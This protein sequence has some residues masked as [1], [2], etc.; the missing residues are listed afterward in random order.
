MNSAHH[1][2]LIP[3][4]R[5]T[6][7]PG[8]LKL[9]A[10]CTLASPSAA[11]GLPLGQLAGDLSRLGARTAIRRNAAGPAAVRI[12][13][14]PRLAICGSDAV[15]AAV[16]GD[17][18]RLEITPDGATVTA[19]T[20]RGAYYG[21]QTLRELLAVH[22]KNLPCQ[23]IEDWPDFA[24]RGVYHDCSR[25]KVPTVATLKA[26]VERLARWKIN[27]LQL[28]IENTFT[29]HRHPAIG[30]GFSP[31]TPEELLDVQDHCR[32]HHVRFI[33]SLSSF[34][35]MEKTLCLPEYNH[36]AETP[37]GAVAG[38]W[39]LMSLCP[40]DPAA[41]K[42]MGEL[43]DEFLPL[44]EAVDFN[45]CCDETFDLGKGRSKARA[46]K[47]GK[48][49]VYLDFIMKLHGHCQRH[50]KRVNLWS[51]ILLEHPGLLPQLP[52]DLVMLNWDY[53]IDGL[54]IPRSKEIADAGL[55]QVV[56]PGTNGWQSHGSRMHESMGNIRQF[57]AEGRKRGAEGLLNT[58]W[59][60]C[61]HRNL[62]GASLHGFAHGA[63]QSWNG[64]AVTTDEAAF[65][66][67]FCHHAFG[68]L[69]KRDE[70]FTN[71]LAVALDLLGNSYLLCHAG[72]PIRNADLYWGLIE[73]L[74]GW[75]KMPPGWFNKTIDF[76]HAPGLRQIISQLSDPSIW[77]TP[78]AGMDAFERTALREFVLAAEMDTLACR[79]GLAAI[80]LRAGQSVPS[81]ELKTL[82]SQTARTAGRFQALWLT[83][84][85]PSRLREN[86]W[87]FRNVEAEAKKLAGR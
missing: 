19:T 24:R 21:V 51:D 60:D 15:T 10:A 13:R 40:T 63:A 2:L 74:M 50:G 53:D 14:A 77:P 32:R 29:F 3:P 82:A 85:K 39:G 17:A 25:G 56:C 38:A 55:P 65:T 31:F 44:F 12:Q 48:G 69:G 57:A 61:L 73:P 26:L 49:Q 37:E 47:I 66:R 81:R 72:E 4:K 43:Y 22:G 80:A 27:E 9:P 46:E 36:L 1:S 86:M 16:A 11:D 7:K 41:A 78:P 34:G 18:Y 58:D 28:Y 67:T 23:I 59:G 6:S 76:M 30:K 62:L 75:K 42:F 5:V 45:I 64:Q 54:R 70:K 8:T 87:L 20:D 33:G 79:R 52:R 84:S 71:K 83:R 68:T 35:H